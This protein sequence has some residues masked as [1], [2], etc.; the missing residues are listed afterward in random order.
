MNIEKR[1][2]TTKQYNTTVIKIKIIKLFNK[3]MFLKRNK[4]IMV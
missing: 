4:R 3:L 1:I 2:K